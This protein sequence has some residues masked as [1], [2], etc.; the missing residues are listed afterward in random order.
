MKKVLFVFCIMLYV[1]AC[2]D[3]EIKSR[4]GENMYSITLSTESKDLIVTALPGEN[5]KF[6]V[7][8]EGP[9]PLRNIVFFA[10][11]TQI[12]ITGIQ[13]K[14]PPYNIDVTSFTI[15][16]NSEEKTIFCKVVGTTLDGMYVNSNILTIRVLDIDP[17]VIVKYEKDQKPSDSIVSDS[18]FSIT[19]EAQD[20]NSG[21]GKVEISDA[22]NL[23]YEKYS[24]EFKGKYF[25]KKYSFT[26]PKLNCGIVQM[27]L[28]VCDNSTQKNCVEKNLLLKINGHPFDE[29]A[30]SL[31]FIKP[32]QNS[33]VSIGEN[34]YITVRA[35]DD[36]SLINKIFYY[37]SFDS[38][39][40]AIEVINKKRIVEEDLTIAIPSNL[41]DGQE[42]SVFVWAEDTNDP[43][44]GS[45]DNAVELKLVAT[46]KDIPEVV[47][48]NP[49][50]NASVSIGDKVVISGVAS[51]NRYAIKEIEL[52]ITGAYQENRK[53]VISPPQ[54]TALFSFDF[55]IPSV[56][57]SGDQLSI[58]VDAKDNSVSE[59]VGTGGPVRL[60]IVALKPQIQIIAPANND[61]FYPSGTIT[62]T[63]FAQ[64]SNSSI[65]SVSYHIEGIE[66]ITVDETFVPTVP[67]K[68]LNKT[69]AYKVSED[70]PEGELTISAE[71][72]DLNDIKG[73]AQPV[74]VKIVDNIKPLVS[75]TSPPYNSQVD[76]GSSFDLVVK[77]EDMNS[78]VYE[79]DA[80]VISPY[81]DSKKL[82]VNKKSDEITFTFNVPDTLISNQII[83]IQ[84]YAIDDSSLSNKSEVVQWRLRVR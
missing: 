15:D 67:Q 73:D 2:V 75:I 11:S 76:A 14:N 10:D 7:Y 24:E 28:K 4:D 44:R 70:V 45:A 37:T 35:E 62:T 12:D 40:N 54:A 46:G 58:Y 56:L 60:N 77:V 55:T 13:N 33:T 80:N 5:V 38:Q 81:N 16:K 30:P 69:F 82:I 59:S 51:S 21:I 66:G 34:L 83:M 71:A 26:A 68:T 3:A 8:V 52:R 9:S 53:T 32:E 20:I 18:P 50:D 47:I 25:S 63:V 57:K 84:I 65:K 22:N 29:N 42:F 72:A 19:V 48:N 1:F 36:C 39:I 17:P 43:P 31:T 64:S 23:I 79:V 41:E 78:L 61:V 74:M 49:A 6:K 27:N